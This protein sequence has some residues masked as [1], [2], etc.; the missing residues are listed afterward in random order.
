M[1]NRKTVRIMALILACLLCLTACGKT[2]TRQQEETA[3]TENKVEHVQFELIVKL[4]EEQEE[5]CEFAIIMGMDSAGEPQW[6][7]VTDRYPCTQVSRVE[8][9]LCTQDQYVFV[10]D[11]TLVT[12]DMATG[13]I[14]WKNSEFGGSGA[15]GTEGND[16]NLYFCG[17]MGPV[18]FATDRE[19]NTL[20][21]IASVGQEYGWAHDIRM[22]G[23]KIAITLDLGPEDRYTPEGFVVYVDPVDYSFAFPQEETVEEPVQI[24]LPALAGD[25][26][27]VLPMDSGAVA[28][29][30][31]DGTVGIAGNDALAGETAAWKHV[32]Q[33]YYGTDEGTL[34]ARMTDGT[35]AS[36]EYDLS[37]WQNVKEL[38]AGYDGLAGLTQDGRILTAGSWKY[39]DPSGWTDIRT[40][41]ES[42]PFGIR[43][44]G[45]VICPEDSYYDIVLSWQNVR[46]LYTGEPLLALLE[47][48]SVVSSYPYGKAENLQGAV[49][50]LNA[51]LPFGLSA[52][53]RLL[54]LTAEDDWV[55]NNGDY[56][57]LEK[58]E[59]SE[60][61]PNIYIE[62][63]RY[64]NIRDIF[65]HWGLIMLKYDGTVDTVNVGYYWD[66]SS[67]ASIEELTMAYIGD[68][69]DL[70]IYGVKNDG[71]VIVAD[72]QYQ[73]TSVTMENYL[74]WRVLKLFSGSDAP[75]YM[76]G[77]VGI[78]PEGTL[79][80]DGDYAGTDLS[81]LNR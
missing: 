5:Y 59:N 20:S 53:G 69:G 11:G 43:N 22:E 66:L 44:D 34:A 15:W 63:A 35:A 26:A 61:Y 4:E 27:Q 2:E 68:W 52:D 10:E 33:L 75:W 19:G 45:S 78:T 6:T 74:G 60:D 81:V 50:L 25:I 37:G 57:T 64:R 12:L 55:Y 54:A 31:T 62:D 16:G 28:V 32:A 39:G 8:E 65:Y 9:V 77:V 76:S 51:S 30:Y 71:S 13:K 1:K 29:L 58:R 23:D 80:G 21:R 47:D 3:A 72:G 7:H 42:E 38:Y 73:Q 40:F 70:R 48:G 46:E 41:Y 49:K 18:F 56:F 14:L 79:V 24:S 36:T 17:Y 67:W